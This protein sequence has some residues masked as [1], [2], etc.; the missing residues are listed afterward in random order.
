[1]KQ[2]IRYKNRKIYDSDIRGY[3]TLEDI[4]NLLLNGF[5]VV[6]ECHETGADITAQVLSQVLVEVVIK[7]RKVSAQ[8]LKKEILSAYNCVDDKSQLNYTN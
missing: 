8:M 1:M 7:Q 2:L 5:D 4:K 3:V 6:V